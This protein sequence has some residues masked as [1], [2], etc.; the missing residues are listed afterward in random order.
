MSIR[1]E[2][3]AITDFSTAAVGVGN[4]TVDTDAWQRAIDWAVTQKALVII[5]TIN[6]LIAEGAPPITETVALMGVS[7]M[8]SRIF[9]QPD[10]TGSVLTVKNTGFAGES[11]CYPIMGDTAFV[12]NVGDLRAGVVLKNFSIIGNRSHGAPQTGISIEGNVD[13]LTVEDVF[14]GYLNGPAICAGLS[15]GNVRGQIR[16]S[17]FS[18]V[19]VRH[20][21]RSD[22]TASVS[23]C[24]MNDSPGHPEADSSN[25][26]T[27]DDI[28]IVFPYGRGIE[29][30][31]Y[32]QTLSSRTLYG[33]IAK[34]IMLHG[35]HAHD[36]RSQG[37]LLHLEGNLKNLKLEVNFAFCDKGDVACRILKNPVTGGYPTDIT[38]EAMLGDVWAGVELLDGEN[39][40][41]VV[42]QN[43][44]VRREMLTVGKDFKGPVNIRCT[45]NI[46][47]LRLPF[48]FT[49]NGVNPVSVPGLHPDIGALAFMA[50]DHEGGAGDSMRVQVGGKVGLL[51]RSGDATLDPPTDTYTFTP[52][53][54]CYDTVR[55]GTYLSKFVVGADNWHKFN[56]RFRFESNA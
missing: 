26:F 34:K 48:D 12:N 50:I 43:S 21:G 55:A 30:V 32:G 18:R 8:H 6:L 31:E 49:M 20:C 4:A 28:H 52:D 14:L 3:P 54:E 45:G 39:I 38:V 23:F 40:N 29:F 19:R 27:L 44:F 41:W 33:V 53:S 15:V 11:E 47:F 1:R 35:R 10:F 37:A 42:E 17:S 22:S 51:I 24:H 2:Y 5:P 9:L 56:G 13:H 16:E 36:T 7:T 25:L 46:S